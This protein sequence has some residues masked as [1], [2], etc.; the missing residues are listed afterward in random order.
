[1][2]AEEKKEGGSGKARRRKSKRRYFRRRKADEEQQG[3]SKKS[4]SKSK[5]NE[6]SRNDRRRRSKKRRSRSAR[7]QKQPSGPSIIDEINRTYT[8]PES[9]FIYTHVVRREQRDAPYEYRPEHFSHTGRKM[10]DFRINLTSLYDDILDPQEAP[11]EVQDELQRIAE[12]RGPQSVVDI[13]A[14]FSED[15]YMDDEPPTADEDTE[16]GKE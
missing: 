15:D 4:K 11:T 10:A 16:N 7:Q 6:R 12:E 9:V 8:L 3:G 1:M 2:M 5:S 14:D 13:W